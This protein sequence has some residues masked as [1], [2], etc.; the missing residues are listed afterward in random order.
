MRLYRNKAL[1]VVPVLEKYFVPTPGGMIHNF[2]GLK[3]KE[4]TFGERVDIPYLKDITRYLVDSCGC[5]DKFVFCVTQNEN[6]AIKGATYIRRFYREFQ[7][8]FEGYDE[9]DFYCFYEGEEDEPDYEEMIRVICL[10]TEG[11]EPKPFVNKYAAALSGVEAKDMV[12]FTGLMEGVELKEK[13]EIIQASPAAVNFICVSPGQLNS[14]QLQELRMHFECGVLP[15]TAPDTDY[16]KSILE[17]LLKGEEYKLSKEISVEKLLHKMQKYRGDLFGEEDI[18]WYLDRALEHSRCR[19]NAEKVILPED[20]KELSFAETDPLK[21]LCEMTGLVNVKKI[22]QEMVAITREE[23]RNPQLGIIR[24]NMIFVGNPGTGKTT[25]AKLLAD[26]MAEEGNTNSVFVQADR[27]SLIAEYVGQTAPLVAKRFEEARG[28]V[29]FVD[30]AGFFLNKD[31]GGYVME[32]MKEFVRYMEL[33]PDVTVIFALYADE[34]NDFLGLDTGL[35]SRI[36]R[37]I[38][39]DDYN[40]NE[41][42]EITEKML[43]EKG[44]GISQDVKKYIQLSF[45]KL[46]VEKKNRFG[47]AREARNLAEAMVVTTAISQYGAGKHRKRINLWEA[48]EAYARLRTSYEVKP[49]EF[50]FHNTAAKVEVI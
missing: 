30:E 20:F 32:A 50:G 36:N 45:R 17:Y 44:Y 40:L 13:L 14:P 26:I 28:G 33:Y 35:S 7:D 15:L 11:G 16:Y 24:K 3:N 19:K 48:E 41:L 25:C 4:D 12:L 9:D 21:R 23:T 5:P 34:L 43:L 47:N 37:F 22:A 49:K 10:K 38:T 2:C 42:T 18:A 39:F 31:S 1:S 27:R 8:D 29:L 6:A 46:K